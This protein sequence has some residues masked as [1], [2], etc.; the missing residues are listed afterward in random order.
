MAIPTEEVCEKCGSRMVIK[1]GRF[2]QF[3]ACE[4][5]PRV[6]EHA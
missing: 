2:G 4:T 3:L 6:P 5:Y 1:F